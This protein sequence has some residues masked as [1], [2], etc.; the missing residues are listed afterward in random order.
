MEPSVSLEKEES[1]KPSNSFERILNDIFKE[2]EDGTPLDETEEEHDVFSEPKTYNQKPEEK[3][4]ESLTKE[5]LKAADE[6]DFQ[7][8]SDLR[9]EINA[10]KKNADDNP[11][12]CGG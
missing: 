12:L 2:N 8:A 6:E 9:D 11:D 4:V 1:R 5:M 7:K 10:I 3:S